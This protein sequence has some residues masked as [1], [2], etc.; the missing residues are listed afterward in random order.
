MQMD[1]FIQRVQE[2]NGRLVL[3]QA[4]RG[5]PARI[6]LLTE[7]PDGFV[8]EDGSPYPRNIWKSPS[9]PA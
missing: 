6:S 2:C 4:P 8:D 1:G 5:A 7:T 3:I 9:T